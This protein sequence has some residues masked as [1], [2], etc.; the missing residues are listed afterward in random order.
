MK[1]IYTLALALAAI[2]FVNATNF[3]GNGKTGF[4]GPVGN[5]SLDINNDGVN[6]QFKLNKGGG[7]FN[8]ILVIYLDVDETASGYGTTAA[9][10]DVSSGLRKA[11]SGYD[12]AS[13]RGRATIIFNNDFLPEFALAFGAGGNNG[14]ELVQLVSG[15]EH[16]S[17]ATP[18]VAGG[19]SANSAAFSVVVTAAQLGLSNTIGFKFIATYISNTGYRADEAIG[20]PMT[21]FMQG[22]NSY[23]SSTSPLLYGVLAPVSLSKFSGSMSGSKAT[24]LWETKSESGT[25]VFEIQKSSNGSAYQ[26]IGSVASKNSINGASYSFIDNLANDT[27]N[28][29]RLKI[30][31]FD[32]YTAYSNELLLSKS[33]LKRVA[34]MGN[35]TKDKVVL[36]IEDERLVDYVINIY[37]ASGTALGSMIYSHSG[38]TGIA[39]VQLPPAYT[40]IA[41]IVIANG[42]EKQTLRV[43]VQ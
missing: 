19:G 43:L 30:V 3:P 20:E 16:I 5:G 12:D 23:T 15:A 28:Y 36:S 9:F 31:D 10:T 40:G 6:I 21:G 39:T 7:G 8:D 13:D 27:K 14:S 2:S 42:I 18:S 1:K 29:Y 38:G 11:I 24:L 41:F 34:L 25:R 35:P 17:I 37:S 32:G 4:G 33:M 26:T 22:W